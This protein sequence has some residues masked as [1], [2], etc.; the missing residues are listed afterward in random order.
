MMFQR[1]FAKMSRLESLNLRSVRAATGWT[2]PET[3]IS[4]LLLPRLRTPPPCSSVIRNM[5]MGGGAASS[6]HLNSLEYST[7]SLME[8]LR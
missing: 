7:S 4:C 1:K 6:R 5:G 8:G 2:G 3:K